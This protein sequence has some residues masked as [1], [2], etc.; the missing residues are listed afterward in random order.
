MFFHLFLHHSNKHFPNLPLIY[1]D[2]KMR[3]ECLQLLFFCMHGEVISNSRI[4]L[5]DLLAL[6]SHETEALFF[7]NMSQGFLISNSKKCHFLI[8][9]NVNQIKL[10]HSCWVSS[11]SN[12]IY[13]RI[14]LAFQ[15]GTR[16]KSKQKK[17]Q[18]NKH[19]AY[20]DETS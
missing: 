6:R 10:L 9:T 20:I 19:N 3:A 7:K 11:F 5:G 18:P 15:S 13:S 2:N 14:S 12:C 4:S 1:L 16:N 8:R 17:I